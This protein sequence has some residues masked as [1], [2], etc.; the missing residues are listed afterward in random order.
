MSCEQLIQFDVEAVTSSLTNRYT[1][2]QYINQQNYETLKTQ[3]SANFP[4]YFSG[5]YD[6]FKQQRNE[7]TKLFIAAGYT[8][9]QT[10]SYRRTLSAEGAA[11]YAR[12]LAEHS[13]KLVA[14]WVEGTT[15]SKILIAMHNG[16]KEDIRY[17]VV[18]AKPSTPDTVQ[19]LGGGGTKVLE[20]PYNPNEPFLIAF[21]AVG[22]DSD[23]MGSTIVEL[24]RERHFEIRKAQK[25]LIA[26]FTCG[27][28]G[29][30]SRDKNRMSS[31][32]FFVA[33][34]DYYLLYNSCKVVRVDILGGPGL[35]SYEV[36]WIADTDGN[37]KPRRIITHP[38][39]M[40]GNDNHTQ[41]IILVTCSVI[42]EREYLVEV[43]AESP[44]V[45]PQLA[46]AA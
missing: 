37:A 43:V 32:A 33:D 45:A 10:S 11:A 42:A 26:T 5:S 44:A 39:N 12:C 19:E 16:R 9:I 1:M 25:E 28:G 6:Q 20:F 22:A 40:L 3:Y 29:D 31:D 15:N 13:N 34:Q 36:D 41:G 18:G 23:E 21:N 2:L 27:A 8:D 46:V 30:D 7:L 24:E 35:A 38:F 4:E 17:T 14:A